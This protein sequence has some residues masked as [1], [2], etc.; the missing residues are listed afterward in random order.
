MTAQPRTILFKINRFKINPFKSGLFGITF[1]KS[2]FFKT[3]LFKVLLAVAAVAL[4]A[5]AETVF[6]AGTTFNVTKTADTNDGSCDSSDCSLREAIIAANTNSSTLGTDTIN[7]PAGTYTL[8]RAGIP[9]DTSAAGDLDILQDVTIVGAGKDSTIINGN[10][11]DR[12]FQNV[13]TNVTVKMSG[14][15]ITGGNGNPGGGAYNAGTATFDNVRFAGNSAGEGGAMQN[16]GTATITNSEFISNSVV[17]S[18]GGAISQ[19]NPSGKLSL[20]NT[21]VNGNTAPSNG[22]GINMNGNLDLDRVTFTGNLSGGGSGGGVLIF[23][24]H[25][26]IKDSTFANNHADGEQGNSF[27]PGGNQG[28]GI[29]LNEVTG[30]PS[31]ITNSIFSGNSAVVG[32]RYL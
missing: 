16:E 13:F 18:W 15:T 8:T 19:Q 29:Y 23:R 1:F 32:G 6:A 22:G 4:L 3:K 31:S 30:T 10:N 25:A 24:G 17:G 9:D 14:M 12:V 27:P 2:K 7:V 26:T 20:T 11:L 5:V 28:G 21:T